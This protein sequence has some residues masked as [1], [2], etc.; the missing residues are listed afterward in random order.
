MA[1]AAWPKRLRPALH[2]DL[3]ERAARVMNCA[4]MAG[5]AIPFIKGPL[6]YCGPAGTPAELFSQWNLDPVLLALLA[7]GMTLSVR[8]W[9]NDPANGRRGLSLVALFAILYVSPFC[10]W[11]SSLFSVRVSHHLLLA[12]VLA[13]LAARLGRGYF[14]R[15]PGGLVGWTVA[16][17]LSMWAWHAPTLY[18]WAVSNDAG[19][20]AMQTSIFAS[21]T[22]FWDRIF[23]SPNPAAIAA[24]LGA[25][26]AMGLLGALITLSSQP[27]YAAHFSTTALWGLTP[28]EDQQVGGLIM[29]APASAVYLVVAL[30][31]VRTLAGKEARA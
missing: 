9:R 30:A 25:M 7:G 17:T 28:I 5:T 15:L 14:A 16:A 12:L 21:A 19:Y 1:N 4:L 24:L 29:W 18:A 13:P 11:G 20:W 8:L 31:L 27:L 23:R 10:A 6:S 26:I 3:K 2:H 22:L